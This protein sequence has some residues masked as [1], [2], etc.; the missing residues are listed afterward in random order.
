MVFRIPGR[1]VET[2]KSAETDEFLIK[3]WN[4]EAFAF[5]SVNAEIP[6]QLPAETPRS[7][8]SAAFEKYISA[9]RVGSLKKAILSTVIREK[10]PRDFNP[11]EFFFRL[12]DTYSTAFTYLLYHPNAGTWCGA[13]PEL[14]L[15]GAGINFSTVALAGTQSASPTVPYQW[16]LKE[17]EEQEWVSEHIRAVLQHSGGVEIAETALETIEAGEVAHLNTNFY[18]KYHREISSLLDH[19]HPTPAVAGLPVKASIAL[20]NAVENHKRG[21]YTGYLGIHS[22]RETRLFVNLRC[23]QIG[24]EDLALYVGG[25]ITAKSIEEAEWEETRLKAKT[26]LNLLKTST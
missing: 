11:T 25:G 12:S 5:G 3:P 10:K 4:G 6:P 22:K 20:I 21:L 17:R 23:M 8:Y 14:L 24:A 16:G 1:Q 18:F 13:T 26:L 15:K 2:F 7:D 19:I 9:F